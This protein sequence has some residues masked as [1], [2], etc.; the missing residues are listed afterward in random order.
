MLVV[1]HQV[2]VLCFRY[3]LENLTERELLEIDAQGDVA[4]CSVTEYAYSGIPG[5]ANAL[6][7][8]QYNWV[9][10]L[11]EAGASVTAEPDPSSANR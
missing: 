6:S 10:P 4:N 9:V 5:A 8:R 3:L 2:V 1:T 11:R 7:L